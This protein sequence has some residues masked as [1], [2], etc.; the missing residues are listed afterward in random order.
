MG[1]KSSGRLFGGQARCHRGQ[2]GDSTK[3]RNSSS[4]T[5]RHPPRGG[6]SYLYEAVTLRHF[7]M[8]T[9]LLIDDDEI[10]RRPAAE[11]LRRAKWE[12]IEAVDGDQGVELAIKHR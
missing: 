11:A 4:P 1:A 6:L 7:L 12:V 8:K 9:I 5:L 2:K 3:C 10:C